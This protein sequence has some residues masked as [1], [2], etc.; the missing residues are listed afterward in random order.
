MDLEE[1]EIST[2]VTESATVE[3]IG[4]N[5]GKEFQALRELSR[6]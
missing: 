4:K 3:I 1:A 2:V 6:D 5:L